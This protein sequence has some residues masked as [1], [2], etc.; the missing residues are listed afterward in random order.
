MARSMIGCKVKLG[1]EEPSIS[2]LYRII[3]TEEHGGR[4]HSLSNYGNCTREKE[5]ERERER[6]A[7]DTFIYL[8]T[9]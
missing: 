7:T 3:S 1:F 8:L 2:S 6:G 4:D 5:R 9:C